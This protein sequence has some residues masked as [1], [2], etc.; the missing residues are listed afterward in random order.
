MTHVRGHWRNGHYVRAHTRRGGS[1]TGAAALAAAA[2][3]GYFL[4]VKP[5]L[6][7][8]PATV[9]QVSVVDGDTIDVVTENGKPG[10]VRVL[11]INAP[12][13]NECGGADATAYLAQLLAG[14]TNV[15]LVRDDSQPEL[16]RYGRILAYVEIANGTDLGLAMITAGYARQLTISTPHDR[17]DDYTAGETAAQAAHRGA[18]ATC[19]HW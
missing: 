3:L 18:W 7:Q 11:G 10:R 4:V 14:A 13:Q 17:A 6:Y 1:A 2:V 15:E 12:E 9:T 16:D 19:P 8:R 5:W